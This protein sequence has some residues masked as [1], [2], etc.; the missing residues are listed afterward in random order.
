MFVGTGCGCCETPPC[1]DTIDGCIATVTITGGNLAGTYTYEFDSSLP[2]GGTGDTPLVDPVYYGPNAAG[3][4]P[5]S[6]GYG[7]A[8]TGDG[9]DCFGWA[10]G[11]LYEIECEECCDDGTAVNCTLAN[12]V[13]Q[14]SSN[15]DCSFYLPTDITISLVCPESC[16]PL[17]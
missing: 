14:S 3:V 7:P 6:L 1:C 9:I 15:G 11:V 8:D 10:A 2:A 16:N 12:P 4:P 5:C 17:P 13:F